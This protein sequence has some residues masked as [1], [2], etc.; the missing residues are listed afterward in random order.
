MKHYNLAAERTR[1]GMTQEQ[2]AKELGAAQKTVCKWEK[3]ASTMP[4]EAILKCA[5]MFGCSVNYLLDETDDRLVR[6]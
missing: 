3:D 2:L 5:S 1:I 4:G 6:P